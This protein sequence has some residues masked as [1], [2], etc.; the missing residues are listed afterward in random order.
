VEAHDG[1][2]ATLG[3]GDNNGLLPL[4]ALCQSTNKPELKTIEYVV[5]SYRSALSHRNLRG[6]LPMTL[7]AAGESSS[8]SLSVIY[9]LVR[10][11]PHV[12]SA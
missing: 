11:D 8:A 7:A 2:V 1:T 6:D 4:H 5:H 10:G 12:V 3:T 9:T